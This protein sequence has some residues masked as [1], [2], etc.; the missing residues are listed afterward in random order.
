MTGGMYVPQ[1]RLKVGL[2]KYGPTLLLNPPSKDEFHVLF[3][4]FY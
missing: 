1:G 3:R 4:L 2:E